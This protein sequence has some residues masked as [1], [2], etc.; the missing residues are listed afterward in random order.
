MLETTKPTGIQITLYFNDD[1]DKELHTREAMV[2]SW[3][4]ENNDDNV[5][6]WFDNENEII[7]DH[8]DFTVVSLG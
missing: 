6:Y 8:G 1:A 7:G 4:G 2:G 5:F 3:D